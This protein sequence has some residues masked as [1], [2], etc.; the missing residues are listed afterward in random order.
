MNPLSGLDAAFLYLETPE[1]PMH[2]GSLHLYQVPARQ[3]AT[4][5]DRAVKH[6]AGRLHLAPVFTRR[7]ATLPL[8]I[9]S[10]MWVED[11]EIDLGYHM[12]RIRLPKPATMATLEATVAKLHGEP[13]DRNRPLW[14]FT[15][16]EGLASGQVAWYSKIHHATLDGAAG[17]QLVTAILDTSP[18]PRKVA[19]P[20]KRVLD[21]T[22]GT[23]ELLAAA[24]RKSAGEYTKLIRQIPELARVVKAGLASGTGKAGASKG[25]APGRG[26]PIGPTT[27][28]NVPITAE[29]TFATASL[30]LAEIKAIARRHDA[31]INDVVLAL[32]SGALRR[33]LMHH[34][35]V[36]R[37]PLVAAM[38]VSL[39]AEGDTSYSTQATM[40]LANLATHLADPLKRLEAIRASAGNAKAITSKAKSII[41]TDFPS[42]G[43]P[44]VLA[45]AARAYG[46][47]Q[48]VK[49]Y[50]PLAN[51]VISNVPGPQAPLYLAGAK[52]LTYWPV[53][54]VEHGLGLNITVE[55]YCGSLDFGLLAAKKAVPDI[56]RLARA[57]HESHEELKTMRCPP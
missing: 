8:A 28:L 51:L 48:G 41:P 36:P 20:K 43:A 54:I 5:Y 4:F 52:M 32:V 24:L 12:R 56:H 22:P 42:I 33:Y 46:Y 18:V 31:K 26:L 38:P 13:L 16:I 49:A 57:L 47:T 39:R 21:R 37:S 7:I 1:T 44:W 35:S 45:A 34:G 17:V 6:I 29:R 19:K 2:V 25:K 15:V 3:R 23:G 10:P 30:P 40:V 27:V 50:P 11:Q 9:A 55:S 14:V 53:S